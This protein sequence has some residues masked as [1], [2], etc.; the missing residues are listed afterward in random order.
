MKNNTDAQN[1]CINEQLAKTP[2]LVDFVL[3]QQPKSKNNR[4]YPLDK[5]QL[6]YV[7]H[8]MKNGSK[9]THKNTIE[10]IL[11][12]ELQKMGLS[13]TIEIVHTAYLNLYSETRSILNKYGI[14]IQAYN[15]TSDS[16]R[17][18]DTTRYP[19]SVSNAKKYFSDLV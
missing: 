8:L 6:M 7:T 4:K 11:S 3:S 13:H 16:Y 17:I 1:I 10:D 14:Q 5:H 2:G 18:E 12:Q 19:N 9:Y 15:S